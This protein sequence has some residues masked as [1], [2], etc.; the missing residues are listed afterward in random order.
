MQE[1]ALDMFYRHF[2]FASGKDYEYSQTI[3]WLWFLWCT[4]SFRAKFETT[5]VV[6]QFSQVVNSLDEASQKQCQ[7]RFLWPKTTTASLG[8]GCW[9]TWLGCTHEWK[10]DT[11]SKY[12][13]C[14][15]LPST[16]KASYDPLNWLKDSL[17]D[18]LNWLNIILL[19]QGPLL[20]WKH[21][22]FPSRRMSI[23]CLCILDQP[24]SL[25]NLW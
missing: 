7:E 5:L 17:Y 12:P 2:Y 25:E 15:T 23:V 14:S 11:Y 20:L 1:E 13:I 9:Q 19:H 8:E 22:S 24:P 21:C 6:C 18:T 4:P 16:L 10:W 3:F